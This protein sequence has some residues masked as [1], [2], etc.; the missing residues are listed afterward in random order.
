MTKKKK[1]NHSI[2]FISFTFGKKKI[3]VILKVSFERTLS[4]LKV[5]RMLSLEETSS[6]FH[7]NHDY[8]ILKVLCWYSISQIGEK[9]N[10]YKKI[11]NKL[12]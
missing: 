5:L 4:I 8:F 6:T 1:K 2:I 12:Q 10:S 7:I 11:K 9:L 3:E